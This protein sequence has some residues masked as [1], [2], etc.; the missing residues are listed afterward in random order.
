MYAVI[1]FINHVLIN[2]LN[3][4][5]NNPVQLVDMS[6]GLVKVEQIKKTK[7]KNQRIIIKV[8][9]LLMVK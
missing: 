8:L 3:L 1:V 5:E 4:M 2:G 7:K 9:N 6:M